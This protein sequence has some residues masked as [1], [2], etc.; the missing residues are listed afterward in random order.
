MG[1]RSRDR[2]ADRGPSASAHA[3][4]ISIVR[5]SCTEAGRLEPVHDTLAGVHGPVGISIR[6]AI[7]S[8]GRRLRWCRHRL[9]PSGLVVGHRN[10]H[11]ALEGRPTPFI[12]DPIDRAAASC[13]PGRPSK[14]AARPPAWFSRAFWRPARHHRSG[15]S[16]ILPAGSGS[17]KLNLY[18]S[19]KFFIMS[20]TVHR[21]P[22]AS[23]RRQDAGSSESPPGRRPPSPRPP[24]PAP[25][26]SGYG[27]SVP[28]RPHRGRGSWAGT[29]KATTT[30]IS[31][32][33]SHA[34]QWVSDHRPILMRP[35]TIDP[36][37]VPYFGP[38]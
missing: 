10:D 32:I 2:R 30:S 34:L 18:G 27:P 24:P 8:M 14:T 31:W 23:F 19:T 21:R 1:R 9:G 4:T 3:P 13:C 33:M 28:T 22:D 5:S 16:H 38:G 37:A 35:P 29:S 15:T 7:L 11:H 36:G 12:F 26:R 6:P 17:C 25:R 20:E